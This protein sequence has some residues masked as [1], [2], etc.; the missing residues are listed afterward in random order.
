VRYLVRDAAGNQLTVGSIG[1]LA[2]LHRQGLI[3]EEDLVRPLAAD[4]WTRAGDMPALLA[5]RERRRERRWAWSVLLLVALLVA[6]LAAA[7]AI[8]RAARD[9]AGRAA[10]AQRP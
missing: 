4:R 7:L 5:R 10:R 3:G 1:E 9:E 6:T 8:S 2:E